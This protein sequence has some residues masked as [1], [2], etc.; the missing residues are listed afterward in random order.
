MQ[1][2]EIRKAC[3]FQHLGASNV[4]VLDLEPPGGGGGHSVQTAP[5]FRVRR[6]IYLV[7]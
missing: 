5:T 3:L 6:L 7:F 1:S 4:T 2:I